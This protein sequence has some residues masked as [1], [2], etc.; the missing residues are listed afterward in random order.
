MRLRS[1][2]FIPADS[3][4]KLHKGD[5]VAA[6]ALIL[7]LEDAVVAANKPAARSLALCYLQAR[8]QNRRSQLWVRI[9]PVDTPEAVIDL[10][11]VMAGRPDGIVQPKTRSVDDVIELGERLHRLET[12]LDIEPGSTRILPLATETPQAMFT[13]GQFSRCDQR[14]AALTWGAEDLR[15]ALGAS[16]NKDGDGNWTFPYQVARAFCL[17]GASAAGVPAIDTI[18]ADFRDADSLHSSCIAARRD[19][20][21]G[22]LAIHPNQVEV[23]NEVFMPDAGEIAHAQRIIA[24]FAAH[25]DAGAVGLDG[26]MLDIPHLKLARKILT[27]AG[28]DPGE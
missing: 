13:L 12:E 8:Q 17:F 15:A 28:M 25:P 14:L 21:S 4:K 23:I 2:L 11:S 5:D 20:F 19:G 10:E 6:D 16:A 1:L 27:M 7:D 22:K 24:A 26:Q 3:E 18:H 9:N